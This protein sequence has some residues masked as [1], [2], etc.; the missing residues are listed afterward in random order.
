MSQM[1]W[2]YELSLKYT[3]LYHGHLEAHESACLHVKNYEFFKFEN[4]SALEASSLDMPQTSMH[5][6][7]L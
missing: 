6:K 5:L 3:L 2:S 4:M 7:E 1:A